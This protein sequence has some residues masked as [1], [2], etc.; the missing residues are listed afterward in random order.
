MLAVFDNMFCIVCVS[1]YEP[2]KNATKRFL[3]CY[4]TLLVCYTNVG[5]GGLTFLF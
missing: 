2:V 1:L 4:D 3:L 5:R